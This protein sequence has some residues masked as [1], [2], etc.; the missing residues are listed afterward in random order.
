LLRYRKHGQRRTA[1]VCDPLNT[2]ALQRSLLFRLAR[3]AA[4]HLS[5]G[6]NSNDRPRDAY[7]I[8]GQHDKTRR[9]Y[10]KEF[11]CTIRQG[12]Q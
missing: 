6:P 9:R 1:N 8:L 3:A 12:S 5:V 4:G 11:A 2:V 10:E 7:V